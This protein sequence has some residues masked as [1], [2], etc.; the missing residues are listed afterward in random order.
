[1]EEKSAHPKPVTSLDKTGRQNKATY[2][3]Y[4]KYDPFL[5]ILGYLLLL[6]IML[7]KFCTNI[8]QFGEVRKDCHLCCVTPEHYVTLSSNR[9]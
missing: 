6:L 8:D 3:V 2:V 7:P 1:L 5:Y 9:I 4:E